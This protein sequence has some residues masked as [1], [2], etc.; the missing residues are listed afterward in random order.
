MRLT[1]IGN[2]GLH[3]RYEKA[4]LILDLLPVPLNADAVIIE[5][6]VRLAA[7]APRDKHDFT[8]QW[9]GNERRVAAELLLSEKTNLRALFRAPP[10]RETST[11]KVYWHEQFLGEIEVPVIGM[12]AL[13]DA[14]SIEMPTMHGRLSNHV[15]AAWCFVSEQAKNVFASTIVLSAGTLAPV[16]DWDSR[17]QVMPDNGARVGTAHVILTS[18]QM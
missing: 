8:L 3:V 2:A 10:P 9:A 11:A 7:K 4:G 5:A 6:T 13:L 17:V 1:T 15:V 12:S 18:E 14:F 16:N